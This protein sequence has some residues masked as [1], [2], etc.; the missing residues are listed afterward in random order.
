MQ[1]HQQALGLKAAGE[2]RTSARRIAA[3]QAHHPQAALA[4]AKKRKSPRPIEIARNGLD[5]DLDERG[6]NWMRAWDFGADHVELRVVGVSQ[7][8]H[9]VRVVQVAA[10]VN[11]RDEILKRKPP[12]TL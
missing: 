1:L 3:C 4:P 7:Q 12:A 2:K 10:D 9:E 11:L 5:V 6:S 8:P